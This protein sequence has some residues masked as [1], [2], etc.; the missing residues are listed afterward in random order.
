MRK[1]DN[2]PPSCVVVTK[3]GNPNFL[4]PSGPVTG[5]IYLSP[6]TFIIQAEISSQEF[7]LYNKK[8]IVSDGV[9]IVFHFNIIL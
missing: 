9:H 1:A 8:I 7:K 5:L 3:S 2:L 6:F 4:E